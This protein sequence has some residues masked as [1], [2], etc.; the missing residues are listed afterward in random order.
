MVSDD[1]IIEK[2]AIWRNINKNVKQHFCFVCI[3]NFYFVK[4]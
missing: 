4:K 3:L 2:D 1:D